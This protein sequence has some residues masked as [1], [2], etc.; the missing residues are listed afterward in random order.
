MLCAYRRAFFLCAIVNLGIPCEG[1]LRHHIGMASRQKQTV[2]ECVLIRV[3]RY[4]NILK[5]GALPEQ[6][7]TALVPDKDLLDLVT[8]VWSHFHLAWLICSE[9][10]FF[11]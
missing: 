8:S 7:L 9:G 2:V 5:K 10:F 3:L 1:H 4:K 6:S 11:L